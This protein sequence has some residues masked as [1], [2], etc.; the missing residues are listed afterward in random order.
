MNPKKKFIKSFAKLKELFNELHSEH[1]LSLDQCDTFNQ[2]QADI[3][4]YFNSIESKL[5][6]TEQS[7]ELPW[8]DPKFTDAW[9]LWKMYKSQQFRFTYKSIGEQGALKDLVD[10]SSGKMEKAIELIHQSI[11]KGWKGFY[12]QKQNNIQPKNLEHKKDIFNRLT[13]IPNEQSN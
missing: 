9:H 12:P 7:V 6:G 1:D 8:N 13:G 11:K 4:N 10:L 2:A 3:I 5:S